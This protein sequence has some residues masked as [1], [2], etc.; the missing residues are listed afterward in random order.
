MSDV[1]KKIHRNKKN[2]QA[3]SQVIFYTFKCSGQFKYHIQHNRK[4]MNKRFAFFIL[5][6]LIA[7]MK[8]KKGKIPNI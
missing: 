3:H 2:F 7:K 8:D 1:F 5:K 6:Y 4:K